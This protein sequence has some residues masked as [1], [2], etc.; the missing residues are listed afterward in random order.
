MWSHSVPRLRVH[1]GVISVISRQIRLPECYEL[2]T[3]DLNFYSPSNDPAA[4]EKL[5]ETGT[6]HF[7]AG[8]WG[9]E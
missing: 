1:N 3:G 8:P 7:T 4:M 5:D 9:G 2:L 6:D